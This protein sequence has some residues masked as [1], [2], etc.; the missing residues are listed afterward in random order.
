MWVEVAAGVDVEPGLEL[1]TIVRAMRG[2]RR[3]AIRPFGEAADESSVWARDV[4]LEG[5]SAEMDLGA[6][7][8]DGRVIDAAGEI[9]EAPP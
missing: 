2:S 1:E 6:S 8:C 3:E 5:V 4:V 7:G 9:E